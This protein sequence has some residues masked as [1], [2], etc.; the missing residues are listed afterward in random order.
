MKS[1][2]NK[3]YAEI[4]F[5]QP[6]PGIGGTFSCTSDSIDEAKNMVETVA[7]N[8]NSTGYIAI[9]ENKK[10]YPEFDWITIERYFFGDSEKYEGRKQIG[11]Q[12][13]SLRKERNLTQNELSELAGITQANIAKIED[14]KYSVGLD[15]LNKVITALK[16]QIKILPYL[17]YVVKRATIVEQIYIASF[18]TLNE[19][20]AF[21][22]SKVKDYMPCEEDSIHNTYFWYEVYDSTMKEYASNDTV[23]EASVY[24]TNNYYQA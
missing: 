12:I 1:P 7:K 22:E 10:K 17:R 9:R 3:Y 20:I 4:N 19:A 13:K 24:T 6:L 23:A 8:N 2:K 21:S 11:F 5:S 15:V 14:G 16:A 18:A